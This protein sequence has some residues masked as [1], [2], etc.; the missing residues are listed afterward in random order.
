MGDM[1][2]SAAETAESM[3]SY[4]GSQ[5]DR[6]ARMLGDLARERVQRGAALLDSMDL[7]DW[8]AKINLDTLDILHGNLCVLG[9]VFYSYSQ[10]LD[11][12]EAHMIKA[13]GSTSVPYGW[14]VEER[15]RHGF[16]GES[17][18]GARGWY[19]QDCARLT[20]AWIWLLTPDADML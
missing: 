4:E 10:G 6:E 2:I 16:L 18:P 8:R 1:P 13:L 19:D 5:A 12:I 9:Q 17:V 15:E 3:I 14:P 11:A 20:A 7:G